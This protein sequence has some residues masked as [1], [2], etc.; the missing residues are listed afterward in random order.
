MKS[1]T[2]SLVQHKSLVAPLRWEPRT[3]GPTPTDTDRISNAPPAKSPHTWVARRPPARK[4]K[5]RTSRLVTPTR[6]CT[7]SRPTC[8]KLTSEVTP[9]YRPAPRGRRAPAERE[10]SEITRRRGERLGIHT[11]AVPESRPPAS[12]SSRDLRSFAF[13]EGTV[14]DREEWRVGRF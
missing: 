1:T 13:A 14:P 3:D 6:P 5:P 9:I 12:I 4:R 10:D 8:L 7:Q 2:T 11:W